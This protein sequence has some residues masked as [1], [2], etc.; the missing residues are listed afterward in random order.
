M[1]SHARPRTTGRK[2]ALGA[3]A[4]GA[5]LTGVGLTAAALDPATAVLTASGPDQGGATQLSGLSSPV[6]ADLSPAADGSSLL[7]PAPFGTVNGLV[8]AVTGSVNSA[9]R[10]AG[11]A[12]SAGSAGTGAAEGPGSSAGKQ[13]GVKPIKASQATNDVSGT[14]D[15]SA[16]GTS[17]ASS[18]SDKSDSGNAV[19]SGSSSTGGD[20][21]GSSYT[22][23][24]ARSAP[25]SDVT[26]LSTETV[27]S[28][29]SQ[30]TSMLPLTHGLVGGV[31]SKVP[32]LSSLLPSSGA[33][34]ATSGSAT[35]G[36]VSGLLNGDLPGLSG[37]D[38]GS[39]LVGGLLSTVGGLL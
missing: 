10:P 37:T 18:S 26:P 7:S 34:A 1:G 17:A 38:Q 22:A 35:T 5:T 25:P 15:N 8:N 31:V 6:A 12:G 29:V 28:T 19:G 11:A 20:S 39:G 13:T 32:V 33:D 21:S 36:T 16:S 3:L 23:R 9:L 4:L 27:T 24:H 2:T 30:V 14:S